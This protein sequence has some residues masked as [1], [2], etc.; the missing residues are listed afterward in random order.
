MPTSLRSAQIYAAE[1]KRAII[2]P[3]HFN[4]AG[5]RYEQEEPMIAVDASWKAVVQWSSVMGE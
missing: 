3:L 4:S 5:I 1:G 2:A